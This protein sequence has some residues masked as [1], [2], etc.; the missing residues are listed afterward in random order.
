VR[1]RGTFSERD[2]DLFD[3]VACWTLGGYSEGWA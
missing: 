2:A 1:E 3:Q